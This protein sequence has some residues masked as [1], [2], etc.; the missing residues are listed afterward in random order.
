MIDR[1]TKLKIRRR[2]RSRKRQVEDIGSQA[3]ENIEKLFFR[4]LPR[5]GDVRRF[6]LSWLVLFLLLIGGVVA[7]TRSLERFY[8][9]CEPAV[10]D[11]T[12]R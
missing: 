10:C 3:E 12:C 7:Q 2:F 8:Q 4:R 1:T 5:L 6:V 11:R 9:E